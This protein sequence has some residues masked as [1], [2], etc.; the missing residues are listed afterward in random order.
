[1]NKFQKASICLL[2]ISALLGMVR[3]IRMTL[4]LSDNSILFPYPEEMMRASVFSNYAILGWIVFFLI[5]IFSLIA[6]IVTLTRIR[7]FAY[8]IIVEGIFLS[9]FTLMHVLYAGFGLIHLFILPICIAIT[10]L[11]VLQTPKE[12]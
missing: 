11:G 1:M 8:F 7:N 2:S 12:F 10:V 4:Y 3:G 5:G 9:F 6:V